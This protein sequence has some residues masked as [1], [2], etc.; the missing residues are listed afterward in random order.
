MDPAAIRPSDAVPGA[1]RARASHGGTAVL[2]HM[3][4]V[5]LPPP[6]PVR[7]RDLLNK[8][9]LSLLSW[10]TNR[11]HHHLAAISDTIVADIAADPPDAIAV[12]GDLTNFGLTQEY[13]AAADWLEHLPKPAHVVPGNHDA[14]APQ[15]WDD[16]PAL[17]SPWMTQ[18]SSDL[19][20]VRRI[21]PLALIGVDSAI[22]S[23][24]FMA[25]GR[26]GLSQLARLERILKALA[27]EGVCR[28]VMIHHPPR[29]GL[30]PWRKSLLDHVLMAETLRS[31]GC[32]LVIHGHSHNSTISRIPGTDIPLLGV[33]SAS[34][35]SEQPL[36]MAAWNRIAVSRDE[37][38]WHI[39]V[40][41]RALDPD[42]GMHTQWQGTFE[43]PVAA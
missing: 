42:R 4:D 20:Y 29:A 40:T 1:A 5:H 33:A 32:E 15:A 9:A 16:G 27:P 30:V 21:G 8:R 39:D 3:S 23:P 14:M 31:A 2:A 12:S 17:W 25:Y 35:K 22:S 26:V 37:R 36:R 41:R 7:P 38:L 43:R 19:P 24:I 28:V 11:R 18:R 13:A 10:Q 6:L 34:L